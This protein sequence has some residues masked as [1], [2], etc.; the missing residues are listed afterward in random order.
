MNLKDLAKILNLS[1]STVS[2]ALND[3]HEISKKTKDRVKALAKE[4]NFT[5]NPIASSLRSHKN[6]TIAVVIPDITNS[7]Y[8]KAIEGIEAVAQEKGYH[9]LI[10]FSFESY[11]KEVG[12]MHHLSNGRVDG[13]IISL[14]AET[15]NFNHLAELKNRK[16][17]IVFFDRVCEEVYAAK[18]TTNNTQITKNGTK[19]LIDKGCREIAF[20]NFSM[21]SLASTQRKQGYLD[22]LKQEKITI[23]ESLIINCSTNKQDNLQQVTNLL[24]TNKNIDAVFASSENLTILTYQVCQNLNIDIP[25]QIKVLGFSNMPSASF[26]NPTLSSITQPAFDMGK[27]AAEVLFKS[28]EKPK[29][30][31][32][33]VIKILDANLIIR[34]SSSKFDN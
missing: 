18:I 30:D 7:F 17:P 24:N 21:F 28:I 32:N 20:L 11:Q 19:H 27:Q 1:S 12:I 29:V 31:Y 6:K 23:D 26:F 9:F 4:L 13:V 25:K 14:S 22:T 5:P 3:S 8:A 33:D 2:R 15:Q 34:D 16:I 10:Y